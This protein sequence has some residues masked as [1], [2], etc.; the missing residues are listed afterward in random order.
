MT[1]WEIYIYRVH[2]H[3]LYFLNQGH[4]DDWQFKGTQRGREVLYVK[5]KRYITGKMK[6][7]KDA[8]NATFSS[9]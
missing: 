5:A 2:T 1:R 9:C 6:E 8:H 7:Q 3:T 4:T